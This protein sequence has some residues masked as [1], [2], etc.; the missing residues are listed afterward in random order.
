M[1]TR[2]MQHI[3]APRILARE[4]RRS[5]RRT[6]RCRRIGIGK[7]HTIRCQLIDIVR[8]EDRKW[9]HRI[10]ALHILPAEVIHQNEQEIWLCR[11][12]SGH[13][14]LCRNDE[15]INR[16][17]STGI[18]RAIAGKANRD[19][20]ITGYGVRGSGKVREDQVSTETLRACRTRQR[21]RGIRRLSIIKVSVYSTEIIGRKRATRSLP[22]RSIL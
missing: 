8:F 3:G 2:H 14:V 5:T 9:C 6:T 16:N 22:S 15:I 19:V 13:I 7:T 4:N 1:T 20:V 12:R 10:I 11:A 17:G 21:D 18:L